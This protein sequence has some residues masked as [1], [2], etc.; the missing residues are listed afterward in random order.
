MSR[1]RGS[2]WFFFGFDGAGGDT[3]DTYPIDGASLMGTVDVSPALVS[4]HM[5]DHSLVRF[6]GLF[7]CANSAGGA[8]LLKRASDGSLIHEIP[9][10]VPSRQP[11]GLQYFSKTIEGPGGFTLASDQSTQILSAFGLYTLLEPTP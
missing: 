11:Q 10:P 6:D 5:K 7:I 4:S 2:F 9:C 8:I 1:P 3:R